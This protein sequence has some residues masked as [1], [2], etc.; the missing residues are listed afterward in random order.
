MLRKAGMISERRMQDGDGGLVAI[1]RSVVEQVSDE[2]QAYVHM[3]VEP[4][5]GIPFYV[6]KG[7][8]LRPAAH[9]AEAHIP[10]DEDGGERSGKLARIDEILPRVVSRRSGFS[11]TG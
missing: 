9:V 10:V 8:R 2:L 7:H 5:S 1:D 3:L 11:V 6:G 4:N